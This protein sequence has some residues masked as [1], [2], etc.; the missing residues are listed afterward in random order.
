MQGQRNV[1]NVTR[2]IRR[3]VRL[4]ISQG[5]GAPSLARRHTAPLFE[6]VHS[7]TAIKRIHLFLPLSR[8][9]LPA[10]AALYPLAL[11]CPVLFTQGKFL[12]FPV[13][14]FGQDIDKFY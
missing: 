7:P 11:P 5:I 10:L 12:H 13:C 14:R 2:T 9:P 1:D 8:S 6:Y 3:K 4:R